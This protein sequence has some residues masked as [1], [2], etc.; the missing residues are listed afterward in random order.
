MR[1]HRKSLKLRTRIALIAGA[2][3]L[4]TALL[5]DWALLGIVRNA[6]FEQARLAAASESAAVFRE[7]EDFLSHLPETSAV[8]QTE[9]FFKS[10]ADDYTLVTCS[11]E[12]WYN[13]TVL[14]AA[15]LAGRVR[16]GEDSFRLTA[17]GR[18]LLVFPKDMGGGIVA[19]RVADI[20]EV[21]LRVYRLGAA[22][23][24]ISLGVAALAIFALTWML[25][26]S[27][28]PLQ[29]LSEG[30]QA[31]AEGA[32]DRRVAETRGDEIGALGRDFNRMARAVEEHIG[33]V[34]AS[35]EKK[36]RFMAALTHEM[37]T[38]LTAISGYAQ[39]LR[40]VRLSE[41]DRAEAL[42][43]IA[44]ESR[45]LDRL[46]K[47]MSHL[48]ELERDTELPFETV[49]I[50]TLLE[51]AQRICG[52]AAEAHGVRL[53]VGEGQGTLWGDP[54]LLTEVLVN[55]TEN[56]VRASPPGGAVRLYAEDGSLVVEDEGCGIPPEE[57]AK[58]TEPFYTVDRSRS[59]QNGGMGLGL[60]I[61]TQILRR[62]GMEM[63]IDSAPGRGTKVRVFTI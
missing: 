26:R 30:A 36:T 4:L 47:K 31:I 58:I 49:A 41:E 39:T 9:Y 10:R 7:Y 33:E 14:D 29:A 15:Q 42:E 13:R 43:T 34:E 44:E 22:L 20:T 38:P 53:L 45:R 25:R 61:T 52:A 37:K 32:Y 18:S 55:L 2:V 17:G 59:R 46:A 50:E 57:L 11:G 35:E 51:A 3:I 6:F 48:L 1:E 19:Y 62:H 60:A 63:E 23:I 8:P 5:N 56:A 24:G 28:K 21:S 16:R 40:T 12:T 54:D 27:L